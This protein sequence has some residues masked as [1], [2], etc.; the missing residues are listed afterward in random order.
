MNGS[1][2]AT[3]K[4]LKGQY[5]LSV[6]PKDGTSV[7]AQLTGNAVAPTAYTARHE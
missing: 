2:E 3:H 4:Q 1:H 6:T 7:N 5:E